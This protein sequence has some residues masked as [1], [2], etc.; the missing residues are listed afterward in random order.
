MLDRI[1][2]DVVLMDVQMPEMDGYSATAEIRRREKGDGRH[3][4]V[5]AM[6]AHAMQGVRERC[7][8]AGMDDYLSKPVTHHELAEMLDRWCSPTFQTEAGDEFGGLAKRRAGGY[9][10]LRAVARYLRGGFKL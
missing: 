3:L 10:P 9:F 1:R 2:Y 4:P 5:I 8:A 7:L 6:T